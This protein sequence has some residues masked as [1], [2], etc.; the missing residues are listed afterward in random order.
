MRFT[1]MNI[2]F[3]TTEEMNKKLQ[4]A[5]GKTK[6]N[7]HKKISIYYDQLIHLRQKIFFQFEEDP[8]S[9]NAHGIAFIKHEALFLKKTLQT[10]PQV[11]KTLKTL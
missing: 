4:R 7:I 11:K 1:M 2:K 5:K 9:R 3:E 8:F 6:L 10:K